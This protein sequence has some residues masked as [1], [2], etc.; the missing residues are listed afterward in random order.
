MF[1]LRSMKLELASSTPAYEAFFDRS[2]AGLPDLRI[3]GPLGLDGL[4]RVGA[5][6]ANGQI[7]AMKGRWLSDTSFQIVMRS[8]L[9]GI[10]TTSTMT[11]QSDQVDIE[12]EDNR[13]VRGRL[14]GD[15]RD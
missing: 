9:D 7:R 13:G 15:S 4:F 5:E 8:M 14:R 12:A 11:F 1:G 10:V 6:E 2:R 3:E